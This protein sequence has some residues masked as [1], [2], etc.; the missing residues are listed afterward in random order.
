MLKEFKEAVGSYGYVI[1]VMAGIGLLMLAVNVIDNPKKAIADIKDAFSGSSSAQVQFPDCK[2][3]KSITV[4]SGSQ[5]Y[6]I[7]C[8]P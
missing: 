1:G 3:T 2:T 7:S 8:A 6:N 5:T 4:V